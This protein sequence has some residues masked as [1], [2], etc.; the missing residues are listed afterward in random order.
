M[1]S[2]NDTDPG[3]KLYATL[4]SIALISIITAIYF[5]YAPTQEVTELLPEQRGTEIELS[6]CV[7]RA[8]ESE[9]PKEAFENYTRAFA[10]MKTLPASDTIRT[11]SPRIYSGFL[12]HALMFAPV[13]QLTDST[14]YAPKNLLAVAKEFHQ[15]QHQ[16]STQMLLAEVYLRLGYFLEAETNLIDILKS[17]EKQNSISDFY[18]FLLLAELR[19]HQERPIEALNVLSLNE[20]IMTDTMSEGAFRINC[21]M[22]KII[23]SAPTLNINEKPFVDDILAYARKNPSYV[24]M[25]RALLVTAPPTDLDKKEAYSLEE[26]DMLYLLSKGNL[27]RLQKTFTAYCIIENECKSL[28]SVL[29]FVAQNLSK[30]LPQNHSQTDIRKVLISHEVFSNMA[31]PKD[32]KP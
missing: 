24:N 12:T 17:E 20:Q 31:T 11:L 2:S 26:L 32:L 28:S 1:T 16:R 3:Q 23:R 30:I 8:M 14:I 19:V 27:E 7:E 15:Q 21:V 5:F 29:Y 13:Q 9:Q 22:M 4:L 18:A 10:L 25:Q 6:Y